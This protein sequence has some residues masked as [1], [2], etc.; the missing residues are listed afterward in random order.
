MHGKA[1]LAA[2]ALV[3][4]GCGSP[5]PD[6]FDHRDAVLTAVD[7]VLADVGTARLA[8]DAWRTSRSTTAYAAVV[9]R[10]SSTSIGSAAGD[11]GAL[12][13]PPDGDALH[14]DAMT[15]LGEADDAVRAA[16]VAVERG[17]EAAVRQ[18]AEELAGVATN[19]G[20]LSAGL[21]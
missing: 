20:Q 15:D 14:E 11:L 21:S 16:R 6:A 10:E 4:A 8:V 9:L 7:S 5:S 19:L 3:L 17:D 2:V 1:A 13:P 18:A 12:T